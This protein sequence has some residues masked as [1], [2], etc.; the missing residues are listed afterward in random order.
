MVGQPD[1]NRAP[2]WV[3]APP[4]VDADVARLR[5]VAYYRHSAQDRQENS[6]QIQQDQVRQWAAANGVEIIH[7]FA[8]RGK[9]GLTAE[10]RHAFNDMM[11]NWVKARGDFALVLCLDVS[12]W[13]RFQDLD[14]SATY[15]AECKRHGKELVYTAIGKARAGDGFYPVM[16]QFERFRSA[17]YS[18]E[19]SDK[20]FRGCVKISQQGYW[21]GGK[22]PYGLARLLLDEAKRP[23]Q[24]LAAGQRKSIQN[25]RVTPAPG[26]EQ[27]VATIRRIFHEFT[28]TLRSLAQIA[29]GLNGDDIKSP[30]GGRWDGGKVRRI[31]V[32]ELYVGTLIY[33]RTSQKL[34]TPT[35]PNPPG[36]WVRTAGAF[37]PV[38]ERAIFDHAQA[39]FARAATRYAPEY[40]LAQLERL[41]REH[42]FLRPSF[43]EADAAAPSL[44]AYARRF[45]SLDAAYQQ[46]YRAAL[47]KVRADV[48][49]LLRG[50]VKD[51][52]AYDDF[53]VVNGRFTVLVQPSVPVPHGYSQYWYFRPDERRTVD[54]TLGVPVSGPDGPQILGYLALPRLM[55]QR[56]G[57]RLFGS[58]ESRLDMYGHTGLEFI[59]Q[60]ARSSS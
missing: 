6:V 44:A 37:D 18:K 19:L 34:K 26:D 28:E 17:Q 39:V 54:I 21:A 32:N 35:R 33:N 22:P 46:A 20:V 7:E 42:E 27:H 24:V 52:V 11:E 59:F 38:V 58:S 49:S 16:I 48:E 13:G 57:V 2:W 5:A 50:L 51:V 1:G 3:S 31:L 56:R 41:V 30:G 36:D 55:V 60:L 8:D 12:R 15:S 40:M 9:S 29:D 25:Q 10:G 43:V 47:V 53:L 23:V 14:Q 45:G 4:H